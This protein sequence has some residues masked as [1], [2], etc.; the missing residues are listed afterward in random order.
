Q[1]SVT[2]RLRGGQ[3]APKGAGSQ[4][5]L[6]APET[7]LAAADHTGGRAILNTN[8]PEERVIEVFEETRAYYLLG[9]E[10]AT[11]AA[12]GSFRHITIRV[13]R[14]GA[15]V[16]TRRGYYVPGGA[17]TPTAEDDSDPLMRALR[18][19]L[20]RTAM[21]M[22]VSLAP[23]PVDEG[24]A[25]ALAVT[26]SVVRDAAGPLDLLAAAFDRTGRLVASARHTVSADTGVGTP[27]TDEIFTRLDLPQPGGYHVRVAM[28]DTA[29]G[30]IASV[31]D[32]ADVPAFARDPLSLSGLVVHTARTPQRSI[33]ALTDFL[34][35]VPTTRRAFAPRE[36]V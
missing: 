7:L 22:Q 5:A 16:I 10:P 4:G 35:V 33:A 23:F 30:R 8:A 36:T 20:P 24:T 18:T 15:Q 31:H 2:A 27:G 6:R 28:R 34:P 13:N 19:L 25:T 21:P 9:F 32:I 26:T 29:T 3:I 11:D 17:D 1:Y 14:P 12:P